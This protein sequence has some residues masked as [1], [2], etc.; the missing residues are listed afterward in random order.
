MYTALESKG[1]R[2]ALLL[3]F[4]LYVLC[5]ERVPPLHMQCHIRDRQIN[6]IHVITL[7]YMQSR[8]GIYSATLLF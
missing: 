1:K 6:M 4:V 7:E 8:V 5:K 2:S 3:R